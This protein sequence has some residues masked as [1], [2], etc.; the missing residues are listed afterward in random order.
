[1]THM[2]L[3]SRRIKQWRSR[4]GQFTPRRDGR[5]QNRNEND[6]ERD[7]KE[8]VEESGREGEKIV[9]EKDEDVNGKML[10]KAAKKMHSQGYQP[11]SLLY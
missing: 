10:N 6:K 7:E 2:S 1:M 5:E 4:G 11:W 3:H 8:Y 9:M